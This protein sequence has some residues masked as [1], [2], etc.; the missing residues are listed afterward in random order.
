MGRER[1]GWSEILRRVQVIAAPGRRHR[2][3]SEEGAAG[4]VQ[5]HRQ[6]QQQQPQLSRTA[7]WV[8]WVVGG[9]CRADGRRRAGRPL[10]TEKVMIL[11]RLQRLQTRQRLACNTFQEV[12][13]QHQQG[14][15]TDIQQGHRELHHHTVTG[16][17]PAERNNCQSQLTIQ[18]QH[19]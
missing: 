19:L 4:E 11:L 2:W 9:C 6:L 18:G 16:T 5:L 10:E 8:G 12:R 13:F 14:A 1:T 15:A 3:L 7:K 17:K